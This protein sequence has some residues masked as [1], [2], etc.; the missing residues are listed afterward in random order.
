MCTLTLDILKLFVHLLNVGFRAV[1]CHSQSFRKTT[2]SK[3]DI[4]YI[5]A[6]VVDERYKI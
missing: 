1:C 6:I 4:E 2:S 5:L 3:L